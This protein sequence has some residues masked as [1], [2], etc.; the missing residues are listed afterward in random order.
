M[1]K[2]FDIYF[3]ACEEFKAIS[4]KLYD[5]C[6]CIEELSDMREWMKSIPEKLKEHQ[7]RSVNSD[8][9]VRDLFSHNGLISLQFTDVGK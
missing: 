9:F 7:V 3:Q 5:K 2:L 4:R 8:I 1:K 6:N